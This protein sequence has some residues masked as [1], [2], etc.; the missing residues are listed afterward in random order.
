MILWH[1]CR[2]RLNQIRSP[3]QRAF[4][5][6]ACIFDKVM[7]MA[8]HSVKNTLVLRNTVF[9]YANGSAAVAVQ[10]A[11]ANYTLG[12]IRKAFARVDV[13][14]FKMVHTECHAFLKYVKVVEYVKE[15]YKCPKCIGSV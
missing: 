15:T 8:L 14:L 11:W 2:Y 6:M 12:A 3:I 1:F 10:H 5:A 7:Y 13:F 9:K 4:N